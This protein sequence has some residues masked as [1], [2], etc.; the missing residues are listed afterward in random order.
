[1]NKTDS[2]SNQS[3][4]YYGRILLHI[5]ATLYTLV[6]V[7]VASLFLAGGGD[8]FM[9][10]DI[11]GAWVMLTDKYPTAAEYL[12]HAIKS[13][14]IASLGVGL[15]SLTILKFAFKNGQRWSWFMM[16]FLPASMTE[17]ILYEINMQSGFEYFFGGLVI[18]A[19]MGL[20]LSYRAFYPG[21]VN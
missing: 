8:K 21:K 2:R 4:H 19:V 5:S 7:W 9:R 17:R 15:F 11:G 1:M 12:L 6:A 13:D 3:F 10:E 14:L 20:L 18:L 16:W